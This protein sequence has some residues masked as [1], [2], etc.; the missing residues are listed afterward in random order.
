MDAGHDAGGDRR[1]PQ[2]QASEFARRPGTTRVAWGASR[3]KSAGRAPPS[4]ALPGSIRGWTFMWTVSLSSG[5][6]STKV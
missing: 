1:L 2:Q 3:R 6:V 4:A 5:G